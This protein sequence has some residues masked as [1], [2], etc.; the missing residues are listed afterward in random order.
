METEIWKKI[1]NYD[2]YEV[3]SFGKI[4]NVNTGRI[5]KTTLRTGYP[6]LSLSK[7]NVK[8]TYSVHI[9]VASHFLEKDPNLE[10]VVNHKN[11]DKCDNVVS[12]LE[13]VSISENCRHAIE[14]DL[15]P[16]Y[17][18]KVIQMDLNEI[19]IEHFPSITEAAKKTNTNA[20]KI[21]S[22]C[23]GQRKTT[24]GYKWK[25]SESIDEIIDLSNF[26]MIPGYTKYLASENGQIYSLMSKKCLKPR[27]NDD[28]CLFIDLCEHK[29]KTIAVHIVIAKTFIPNEEN[30]KIVIHI[31][32]NKQDN[33]VTNLKWI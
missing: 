26:K 11:G 22:V 31:N 25:Y 30:K 1:E 27:K 8:K 9:L 28:G 7:D 33:S 19:V 17:K 14:N 18:R 2:S 6:S 12:N 23:L 3:S 16:I 4:R 24:G 5:L 15:K 32:K 20:K 21:S 13:W 29:K 10:Q